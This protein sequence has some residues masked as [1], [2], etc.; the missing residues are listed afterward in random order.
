MKS[1]AASPNFTGIYAA[2]VAIINTKM[3]EVGELL[4]KRLIDQFKK[5]YKRNNKVR[6]HLNRCCLAIVVLIWLLYRLDYYQ[7]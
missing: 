3:P 6:T 2:L 1:Q 4:V 5:S 7:V